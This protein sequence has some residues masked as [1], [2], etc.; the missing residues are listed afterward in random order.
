MFGDAI[1]SHLIIG[2][3]KIY[4]KRGYHFILTHYLRFYAIY[5]KMNCV[6]RSEIL[7]YLKRR[8]CSQEYSIR[9]YNDPI[10]NNTT[11]NSFEQNLYINSFL[12]LIL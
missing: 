7:L 12:I 11:D 2:S 4:K 3:D 6:Q 10:L 1:A 9:A 5:R 8:N